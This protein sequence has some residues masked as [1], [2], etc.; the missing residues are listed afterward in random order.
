MH[1]R[2]TALAPLVCLL[3]V[4][5]APAAAAP[6]PGA[7]SNLGLCSPYLA[8]LPAVTDPFTGESLG[9]NTRSGVNLLIKRYGMLQPDRLENPGQLYRI[10]A[11]EHPTASAEDEC[12]QRREP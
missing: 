4:A 7:P 9:G 1:R 11:H 10:R 5:P 8:S 3:A 2:I 6:S 12:L